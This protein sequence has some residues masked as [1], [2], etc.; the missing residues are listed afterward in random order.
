M[1]RQRRAAVAMA[2]VLVAGLMSVVDG[3]SAASAG[4]TMHLYGGMYAMKASGTATVTKAGAG[5]YSIS[6]VATGLPSPRTLKV[7]PQRR[8]YL[9]WV[10]DGKNPKGMMGVLHLTFRQATG[11]YA[12]KGMV[13]LA[14]VTQIIVTADTKA[15]QQ[16]PT[17]PMASVLNSNAS[18]KM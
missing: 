10:I 4:R 17:M 8:T 13:M 18:G 2:A 3:A 9:A 11:T 14:H 16:M 6:I 15:T 12:A 7:K 1:M 5:D